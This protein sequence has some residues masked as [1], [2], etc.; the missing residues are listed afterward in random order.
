MEIGWNSPKKNKKNPYGFF[1]FPHHAI[2]V[3]ALWQTSRN[4]ACERAHKLTVKHSAV[5]MWQL[6]D[7][8]SSHYRCER[9][10][11]RARERGKERDGERERKRAHQAVSVSLWLCPETWGCGDSGNPER[12]LNNPSVSSFLLSLQTFFFSFLFCTFSLSIISIVL[13]SP[14]L[15]PS[16]RSV[17]PLSPLLFHTTEHHRF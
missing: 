13:R 2:G 10:R 12:L 9:K 17:S 11:E 6:A 15:S 7:T 1:L 5:C 3:L 16:L 8:Y 14:C 4:T